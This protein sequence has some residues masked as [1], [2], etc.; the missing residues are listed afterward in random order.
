MNSNEPSA[1]IEMQGVTVSA[2]RDITRPVLEN[3]NWTVAPG[4]FWVV[5]GRQH[6][7]KTDLLMTA[8]GLLPPVTGSCRLWGREA[9][10]FGEAE[11]PDRLRVGLVFATGQLF[12]QLTLAENI[13]L[14]LR[15]HGNLAA[16]EAERDLRGLLE[17]FELTP[18][19]NALPAQVSRD[20]HLRTALARALVLKPH[21][22]LCDH[23]LGGLGPRHRQW[24]LQFLDQLSRGHEQLG[25]RP[26]TLVVTTEELAYWKS[27]DR[28]FALLRDKQLIPLGAWAE[29]AGSPDPALQELLA[30]PPEI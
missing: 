18:L 20:W 13:A 2:L 4:E 25:G 11:L 8:A 28:R 27:A 22:L 15:Y 16:G 26:V 17:F 24:W 1:A 6:S 5:A 21:L 10:E 9:R 14:P 19:A 29:L 30:A 12:S 23:P 7:G 3:V